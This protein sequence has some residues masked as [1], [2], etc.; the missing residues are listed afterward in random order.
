M[1]YA[2]LWKRYGDACLLLHSIDDNL[3]NIRLPALTNRFNEN[4]IKD[5]NGC[6]LLKK[7]DLLQRAEK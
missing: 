5:V 1:D 2:C 3:I 4:H 6:I 7:I